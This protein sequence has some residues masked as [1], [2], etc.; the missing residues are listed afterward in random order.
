VIRVPAAAALVAACAADPAPGGDSAGPPLDT[1]PFP[2]GCYDVPIELVG[3]FVHYGDP[4]V[5]APASGG[6]VPIVHG[7]QGSF[8]HID[9]GLSV[10]SVHG[11]VRARPVV[12]LLRTGRIISGDPAS[13]T[14]NT[15]HLV[16]EPT[17]ECSGTTSALRAWLDDV[18]EDPSVREGLITHICPLAGEEV[19]VR[20]EVTDLED[21]RTATTSVTATLVLDPVDVEA[22]AGA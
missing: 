10:G 3:G 13:T 22:C 8:W 4:F 6:T 9:T 11:S 15:A 12:T 16:L 20:W 18:D 17:G 1:G 2:T 7:V 14:D 19:E 21:Q 5:A